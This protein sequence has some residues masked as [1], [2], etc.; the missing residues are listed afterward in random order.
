MRIKSVNRAGIGELFVQQSERT[1]RIIT[2]I[3]KQS[4]DGPV[5]VGRLGLDGDEQA[6]LTVHGGLSKAVYAYPSEHYAFWRQHRLSVLKRDEPLAPGAMGE[7][8]TLEGL[9]EED[10]WIGDRLRAGAVL[11]EVTE[12][13]QPCFKFAAK[14]G[15]AHAVKLML[16][17]GHTG[18][19][20]R[21]LETGSLCAGDSLTLEPGPRQTALAQVNQRRWRG[22]QNELF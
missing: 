4:V 9:L 8:L 13:R 14:M 5:Q 22:R 1:R 18:F 12:P 10:V 6:D 20:L 7:N 16:Q 15:F 3:H 21:V 17:S 19:Y 2:G 11:M